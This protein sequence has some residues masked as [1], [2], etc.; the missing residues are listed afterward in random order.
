MRTRQSWNV[1][2]S[3]IAQKTFN[4]IRAIVE[5]MD[6]QPN[7]QKPMIALSI[8]DPTV[9]GNLRPHPETLEATKESVGCLKYCGYAPST[10]HV[11]A[12]EAV[13][14]YCSVEGATIEAKDVILCSGC[15]Q[16]LDL[17]ITALANPGQNIL[18]P[19]PGFPLY[20]TLAEGLGISCKSYNLLPDRNWEID[21]DH[22]ESLIDGNT[23]A[24][25]ISN[26]SNP[27]GSVYS[28]RHLMDIVQVAARNYV[29]IIA[30]EIYDYFVFPGNT[31]IPV[32]SLTTEVPVLSCGGLTKRFMVPGWRMGWILIHDRNEILAQ[33]VRKGL[34][35]L[36]Q[37]IIG[38]NTIVQGALPALLAKTP[39]SFFDD[40]ISLVKSNADLAFSILSEVPGLKPLMPQGAMYM[41]IEI[42]MAKFPDISDE[43]DFSEKMVSEQSVFCLPGRCFDYPNYIR[44]VLTVPN[45]MMQEASCR[46]AEF[47]A[48]HY[49]RMTMGSS[50]VETEVMDGKSCNGA[51]YNTRP[52]TATKCK[53]AS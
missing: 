24:I 39:Q 36:S 32:A 3:D 18:V 4:P 13:A 38:S 50:L 7:P 40:A 5:G 49:V 30:D 33:E 48:D 42:D 6:L 26:P 43:L 12:R 27:C 17:C 16:S 44:I 25:V 29:V 31:F 37:R 35:N 34:Q 52:A 22:M 53:G 41:M 51:V 47:C 10:G 15:S 8:G 9:F 1:R 19:R 20:K 11:S 2:A 14:Q 46:I 45:E 21:L 23:C 28:R